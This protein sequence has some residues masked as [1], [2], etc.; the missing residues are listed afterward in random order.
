MTK[1]STEE[2]LQFLEEEDTPEE[3]LFIKESA[4]ENLAVKKLKKFMTD[5]D[6]RKC[7]TCE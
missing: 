4:T 1:L 2:Y 7:K 5:G 6:P 3:S